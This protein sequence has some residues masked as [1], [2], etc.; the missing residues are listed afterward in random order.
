MSVLVLAELDENGIVPQTRNAVTAAAEIA[1]TCILV[2][3]QNCGAAADAGAKIAGVGRVLKADDAAYAN[4]LA[5]NV[6]IW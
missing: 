2:A 4:G 1:A 5:E 6:A 3:G